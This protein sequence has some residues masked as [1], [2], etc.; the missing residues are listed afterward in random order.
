MKAFVY[1]TETGNRKRAMDLAPTHLK[2]QRLQSGEAILISE[3]CNERHIP[4]ELADRITLCSLP[5]NLKEV[6]ADVSTDPPTVITDST[7]DTMSKKEKIRSKLKNDKIT[8][9]E[10]LLELLE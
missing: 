10:A 9:R 3:S 6:K 8:E 7:D 5:E 2:N 4:D 1:D